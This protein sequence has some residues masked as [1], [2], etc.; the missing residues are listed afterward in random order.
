MEI[1]KFKVSQTL[2]K[3]Y[4]NFCETVRNYHDKG[5]KQSYER[6]SKYKHTCGKLFKARYIDKSIE[7]VPS[8]AMKLGIYFEYLCTGAIPKNGIPPEPVKNTKTGT[9]STAYQTVT[10]SA[11]F[12]K[13]ILAKYKIKL[14]KVNYYLSD[15]DKSGI[16]DILAEWNKKKVIIDLK[17]SGFIDNKWDELGWDTDTL[18]NK[19]NLMIQGVHYKVLAKDILGIDDIPFYYFIFNSANP[20]DAKIILQ[21]VDPDEVLR[22]RQQIKDVKDQIIKLL[23]NP[24]GF[25]AL[26]EYKSCQ[27]CPLYISCEERQEV[28]EVV[29]VHYRGRFEEN[30]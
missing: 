18:H 21:R 5:S 13:K 7:F 20:T 23:H 16:L 9:L 14:L 8:E 2:I 3:E 11:M 10:E 6:F 29:E 24:N 25:K 17:Y 30:L 19:H 22:H 27:A 28:P 4:Q 12:F 1:P 15:D 26:P